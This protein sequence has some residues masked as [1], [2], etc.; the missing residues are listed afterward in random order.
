MFLLSVLVSA[1]VAVVSGQAITPIFV[2]ASIFS[3]IFAYRNKAEVTTEHWLIALLIVLQIVS[4]IWAIDYAVS[5]KTLLMTWPLLLLGGAFVWASSALDKKGR[6]ENFLIYG[7][8]AAYVVFLVEI[9]SAGFFSSL[10]RK[11]ISDNEYVFDKVDLN[12][13]A[14]FFALILWPFIVAVIRKTRKNRAVTGIILSI[15]TIIFSAILLMNLES[16]AAIIAF[17]AACASFI[18]VMLTK[19]KLNFLINGAVVILVCLFPIFAGNINPPEIMEKYHKI[20]KSAEHRLYIWKFTADKISENPFLGYGIG[21]SRVI[22]DGNKHI[23]KNGEAVAEWVNL[24]LH[25]HNFILQ[26][27]LELGIFGAFLTIFFITFILYKAGDRKFPLTIQAANIALVIT[28][29]TISFLS[30]GIWQS[31]WISSGFLVAG[32]MIYMI[33]PMRKNH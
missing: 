10:I 27:I 15:L 4:L 28:Y 7:F 30:F 21:T 33:A 20:P 16:M 2:A 18:F 23:I 22:P 25:P 11:V 1:P 26:I 8:I 31:W 6:I 5:V 12:R 32:V 19:G 29:L 13:G 14:C 24:P 9:F 17:F 3:L